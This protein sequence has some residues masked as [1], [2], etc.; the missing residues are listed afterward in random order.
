MKRKLEALPD[1]RFKITEITG[2]TWFT[3]I[4]RAI[5]DEGYRLFQNVAY[6]ILTPE[7]IENTVLPWFEVDKYSEYPRESD[8][9]FAFLHYSHNL[10]GRSLCER[11]ARIRIQENLKTIS[12]NEDN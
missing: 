1:G 10:Y 11:V 8:T 12:T 5:P 6:E 2:E 4:E 3:Q 7:Q 9:L